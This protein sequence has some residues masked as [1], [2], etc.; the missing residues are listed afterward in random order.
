MKYLILALALLT[1]HAQA[2]DYWLGEP[3]EQDMRSAVSNWFLQ[4]EDGALVKIT[5]FKKIGGCERNRLTW[6]H[7]EFRLTLDAAD[8]MYDA[9]PDNVMQGRANFQK[10]GNRWILAKKP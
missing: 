1:S 8:P 2:N 5:K 3:N 7:C 6:F 9:P 4:Q 10:L